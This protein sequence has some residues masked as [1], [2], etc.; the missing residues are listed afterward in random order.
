M[1]SVFLSLRSIAQASW[2][3]FFLVFSSCLSVWPYSFF[4]P[5]SILSFLNCWSFAGSLAMLRNLFAAIALNQHCINIA[6]AYFQSMLVNSIL[7][8][9][10]ASKPKFVINLQ[11]LKTKSL[12]SLVFYLLLI[13]HMEYKDFWQYTLCICFYNSIC[14]SGH[15]Q[16]KIGQMSLFDWYDG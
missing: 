2:D 10:F 9:L 1:I 12:F 15:P 8:Q 13:K 11:A 3:C 5:V 7:L 14:S 16:M 6:L 4:H